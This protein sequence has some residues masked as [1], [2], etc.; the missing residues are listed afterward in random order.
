[1]W[2]LERV[3]G[4]T[5]LGWQAGRETL[6]VNEGQSDQPAW[7]GKGCQVWWRR[8]SLDFSVNIVSAFSILPFS[9][10]L[11][12]RVQLRTCPLGSDSRSHRQLWSRGLAQGNKVWRT[13]VLSHRPW[14]CLWRL[15]AGFRSIFRYRSIFNI[16]L[17]QSVSNQWL[18]L[19]FP[20]EKL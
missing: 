2:E 8:L 17:M 10:A 6:E 15:I 3:Q 18:V 7:G 19:N 12:W 1:M 4:D 13:C 5:G 14:E 20:W 11:L 9:Q 16:T